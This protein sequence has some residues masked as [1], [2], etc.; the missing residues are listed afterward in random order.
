MKLKPAYR[1]SPLSALFNYY[2]IEGLKQ[3]TAG[4]IL[5]FLKNYNLETE[6][7]AL[8]NTTGEVVRSDSIL[9]AEIEIEHVH[10]ALQE[11]QIPFW[12]QVNDN[13]LR[14]HGREFLSCPATP[15]MIRTLLILLFSSFNIAKKN[16][17]M[18]PEFSWRTSIHFHLNMRNETV[19][20]LI[21]FTVLYLLFEDA[22]FNFV[23][24]DR[25]TS[26]FCVPLQDTFLPNTLS[27]IINDNQPVE[28]MTREW[29]KYTALN[30][31]PL[32]YNDHASDHPED[33]NTFSGK[34]TVEF[35]HLEGTYNLDKIIRWVNLILLLQI[36][37]RK[38]PLD[39][40]EDQI[41][42]LDNKQDYTL[43]LHEIFGDYLPVPTNFQKVLFS[44]ISSAKECF[45]PM[46]SIIEIYKIIDPKQTGLAAMI[47][48]RSRNEK[49]HTRQAQL[50]SGLLHEAAPPGVY[51][52]YGITFTAAQY[53]FN[54]AQWNTSIQI[55]PQDTDGH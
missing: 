30:L 11:I 28:K 44:S 6:F 47:K 35:R 50:K 13:S 8:N 43:L 25:R 36:A 18:M 55:T 39:Y 26:N 37:S 27:M 23:G 34:G 49:P 4:S 16:A 20:Q 45:C 15:E 41:T 14:N 21:T 31:R 33:S 32:T 5:S 22:L 42:G 10:P 46:P 17:L 3:D 2:P 48:L 52:A 7:Q 38:L 40:I 51:D 53:N 24:G 9:G 54:T 29:Y 19:E 1:H 12:T